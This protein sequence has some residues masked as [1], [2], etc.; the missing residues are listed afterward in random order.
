MLTGSAVRSTAANP[1]LPCPRRLSRP[2][3]NVMIVGSFLNGTQKP[4][5]AQSG[6][7]QSISPSQSLSIMSVQAALVFSGVGEQGGGQVQSRL[8]ARFPPPVTPE[9]QVRL[10]GGSQSSPGSGIALPQLDT[11]GQVQ[12]RV[13]GR[14]DPPGLP[15]HC[16]TFPG[17][18]HCSGGSR[19][20]VPQDDAPAPPGRG[21][22]P[23]T[24]QPTCAPPST[25]T[26]TATRG[27]GTWKKRDGCNLIARPP[28][29]SAHPPGVSTSCYGFFAGSYGGR[30]SFVKRKS[31]QN[32]RLA[33]I[34]APKRAL[35]Q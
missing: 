27:R 23:P 1:N 26:L 12:S 35:R 25:T 20:A 15:G 14:K 11:G 8:Q 29:K 34:H 31:Y 32:L 16:P 3:K 33:I 13:H 18:S 17:G 6:S 7:A 5:P 9:G 10:P 2:G 30:R 22:P 21:A 28:L 19:L 4:N 24:P